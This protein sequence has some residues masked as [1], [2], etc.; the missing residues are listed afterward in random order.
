MLCI[1]GKKS[2]LLFRNC[3]VTSF[4]SEFDIQKFS[5]FLRLAGSGDLH[6]L[7]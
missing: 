2:S 5:F 4:S 6:G 1:R 3:A 7:S